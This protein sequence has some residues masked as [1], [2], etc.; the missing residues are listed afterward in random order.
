MK[1]IVID[2][3]YSLSGEIKIS[4][5]KNSAVALIPAALL[6]DEVVTITNVPNISDI[7]TLE[8][9]LLY[10]GAKVKREKDTITIDS[11]NIK[12]KVIPEKMAKKIR[13]SYY[14]MGALLGNFKRSE[15]YFPGGCNIGSRPIN[16]H[17]KGFEAL[18]ARVY[19]DNNRY[20]IEAENLVGKRINLDMASVGATINIMLAAVKAEGI[21]TIENAAKEPE[22]VNV[23]TF[24]NTMGAKIVGAGTSVIKIM[25]VNRLNSSFHEIIPDRMEAGTYLIIGSLLGEN[26]KIS[27]IIPKHLETLTS[28]LIEIG[29]ELK[30]YNDYIIINKGKNY[31]STNI[32]TQVHPG[33]PTDLQ[34]PMT[35]LL[36]QCN[37]ISTIRETIY[38]N[39]FNNVPYLNT[40]GAD[41][42]ISNIK[43]DIKGPTKL[44]G[45]EVE[46]TDLRGGA[47]LIIAGL[48]ANG[49]TTVTN[50]EHVLRG[51][52]DIINKLQLVGS[53]IKISE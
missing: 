40:M 38:E 23:A 48:I 5:A 52:E 27:N 21:T 18:G 17:L 44:V 43:I 37:G 22:I 10:L 3:G 26:L 28:K 53:K 19:E 41:I 7:D 1:K 16:L 13:A 35:V 39:R 47:C 9:I 42:N 36:T 30:T 14:F 46:A 50:I 6:C 4:G 49:T 2:G 24:L 11:S 32:T 25:G 20:I 51:Y 33:F 34:Q 8:E 31:K 12:N 29:V 45:K 15:M